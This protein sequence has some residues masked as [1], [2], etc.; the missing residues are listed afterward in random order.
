M[1][2]KRKF[3]IAIYVILITFLVSILIVEISFTNKKLNVNQVAYNE[4][5]DISY[6]VLLKDKFIYDDPYLG[7]GNSYIAS[8]IDKFIVDYKYMNT[9]SDS[10]NYTLR[11]NIKARLSVYDSNNDSK[12]VYTKDY[13]LLEDQTIEDKGRVAQ[14]EIKD[15]EINYEEYNRIINELKREVIPNATLVINFN[16]YFKGKSDILE[17]DIV[18]NKTSSFT[19]PVSQRT[20]NVDLQ[21]NNSSVNKTLTDTKSINKPILCLIGGTILFLLVAVVNFILYMIRTARKKSAYEQKVN[22]ILREFDRAITEAR[23]KVKLDKRKDNLIEVKDFMELL[24]VHDNLNIPIIYYRLNS[25]ASLFMIR[26]DKQVYYNIIRS[27]DF[28]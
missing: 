8:L 21:K 19:I 1:R 18:S 25:T 20:I 6:K 7:E 5:S 23:G 16:T 27:D 4:K 24:D 14:I 28:D 9:L 26:D 22:K 12:P 17:E 11:Y 10:V 3:G 15:Q 2:L 13:V